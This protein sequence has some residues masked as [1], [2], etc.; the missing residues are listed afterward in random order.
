VWPSEAPRGLPF[1][2][3]TKAPPGTIAPSAPSP[4]TQAVRFGAGILE[5]YEPLC[6]PRLPELRGIDDPSYR[7]E[8]IE[9]TVDA[10][11]VGRTQGSLRLW[12][13]GPGRLV[14]EQSYDPGWSADRGRVFDARGRLGLEAEAGG[15]VVLRYRPP[16]FDLGLLTLCF[17]L[18]LWAFL[19]LRTLWEGADPSAP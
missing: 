19:A 16:G 8:L 18:C 3:I 15:P 6:L 11:I 7:G 5:A 1:V 13:G 2:T 14:I 12:L 10:R 9:A 17:A 4:M